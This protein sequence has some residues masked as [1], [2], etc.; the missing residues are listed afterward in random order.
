MQS[1]AGPRFEVG[2]GTGPGHADR[3]AGR[4]LSAEVDRR[5]T[6]PTFLHGAQR[7]E[8]SRLKALPQ[9]SP[10]AYR[11]LRVVGLLL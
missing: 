10:Q 8:A 6:A 5:L 1:E 2:F 11:N 7:A 4:P 3:N 9:T